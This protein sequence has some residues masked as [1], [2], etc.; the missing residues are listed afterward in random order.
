MA[1]SCSRLHPYVPYV[2]MQVVHVAQCEH[3][4]YNHGIFN[5]A[6]STQPKVRK[7]AGTVNTGLVY[8]LLFEGMKAKAWACTMPCQVRLKQLCRFAS[9]LFTQN[10]AN[11]IPL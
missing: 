8:V 7:W 6:S 1:S 5:S 2:G 4:G 11:E 10:S 9:Q 3:C